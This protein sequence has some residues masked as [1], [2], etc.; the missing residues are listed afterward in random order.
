MTITVP[1]GI[2]GI[3]HSF[4]LHTDPAQYASAASSR[5]WPDLKMENANAPVAVGTN[6]SFAED[7]LL[8][9]VGKEGYQTRF[10]TTLFLGYVIG[11]GAVEGGCLGIYPLSPAALGGMPELQSLG[12]QQ[13]RIR[14]VII[15]YVA[16]NTTAIPGQILL[17][18]RTDT[19][20]Y[21]SGAN[22]V[23]QPAINS[24]IA[25]G[26]CSSC[27]V[28]T[29]DTLPVRLGP[30]QPTFLI[31][32][33]GNSRLETDGAIVV[34]Q[35]VGIAGTVAA[36]ITY[37]TLWL[38]LEMDMRQPYLDRSVRYPV[39]GTMSA[40]WTGYGT[41][42]GQ[43]LLANS[44]AGT[45]TWTVSGNFGPIGVTDP[46]Y[47]WVGFVLDV[48]GSAVNYFTPQEGTDEAVTPGMPIYMRSSR[49]DLPTQQQTL[50]FFDT[51]AAAVGDGTESALPGELA[52]QQFAWRTTTTLTATVRMSV[53]RVAYAGDD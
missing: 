41:T 48:V 34:Q 26:N 15:H 45:A 36:P 35:I 46:T 52:P 22:S 20:L 10:A 33:G 17:S 51:Y 4:E 27:T 11:Y 12:F 32:S 6:I 3:S 49:V 37:G 23:G 1:A 30:A 7:S 31:A 50:T 2:Q 24:S 47:I 14:N 18:H 43:P 44:T 39:T 8:Q 42:D 28:W 29:N 19:A 53:R 25:T 38:E 9:S 5:A 16:S 21:S 40:I 13:M